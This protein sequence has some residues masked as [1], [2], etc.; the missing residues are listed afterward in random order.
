MNTVRRLSGVSVLLIGLG[1]LLIAFD[2][3]LVVMISVH[4][5]PTEIFTGD[6]PLWRRSVVFTWSDGLILA[7]L[8]L[9]HIL[10]AWAYVR[11]RRRRV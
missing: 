2:A 6:Q 11:H 10:V 4:G 1:A 9:G 8:A 3:F 7:A 5:F